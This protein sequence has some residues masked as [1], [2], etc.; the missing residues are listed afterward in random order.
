MKKAALAIA[1]CLSLASLPAGAAGEA[2]DTGEPGFTLSRQVDWA[3]GNVAVEVT[4]ALNAGTDALARAKGDAETDIDSRVSDLMLRAIASIPIDSSHSFGDLLG[5]DPT[6]FARVNTLVLAAPR[7]QLFLTPDFS[8]LVARYLLPLFGAQGIVSPLFPAHENPLHRR[9]GYTA[10]R[11]FTGLL[12]YAKGLLPEVGTSRM[13]AARPAVFPRL[14]DEEM[15][16]VLDR[17]MCRPDALARWGMVGY[18]QSLDDDVVTLRAGLF[19]LRLAARGVF[20]DKSTDLVLPT[21]GVRQL[22]TLPENIAMLQE[23]RVVIVYDSL[24]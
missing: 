2:V 24:K 20:G 8:S 14:W 12:V 13:V 17:S 4:R 11:R 6:L 10:T 9:L 16:L 21:R 19:P 7:D 18:A 3:V 22:L 5:A 23:G 15:N 1:A